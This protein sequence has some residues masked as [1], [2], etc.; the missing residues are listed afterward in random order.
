MSLAFASRG[1]CKPALSVVLRTFD[2]NDADPRK[3]RSKRNETDAYALSV[4]GVA[5]A[6]SVDN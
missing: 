4:R 2:M 6:L 3:Y 1:R 5:E